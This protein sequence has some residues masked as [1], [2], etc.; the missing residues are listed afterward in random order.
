MTSFLDVIA[1]D[2]S[3]RRLASRKAIVAA[4]QRVDAQFGKF[5]A[6]YGERAVE[7][8]A[9]DIRAVVLAAADEYGAEDG[10]AIYE[11]LLTEY[12]DS[13][14]TTESKTASV[15]ESRRVKMCPFHKEVVDISLA[16]GEPKAGFEAMSQHWGGKSHCQGDDYAGD[17]CNFK[18][19]M[20]TQSFWDER[21]EKAEQR[22]REREEAAELEAQ[23]PVEEEVVEDAPVVE[24]V[25]EDA[26]ADNV[27]EVDFGGE[28]EA[29]APVADAPEVPMSM[30][31]S[32]KEA[33]C[34]KCGAD[35]DGELCEDCSKE[36][37]VATE[38]TGLGG[39]VP[40]IDKRKWTPKTVTEID[41][42]GDDSR[43]PT[44]RQDVVEAGKPENT[45]RLEQV[46]ENVTERVDVTRDADD[47][48]GE[49]GSWTDGPKSAISS[50][51]ESEFD[52]F[53]PQ[54]DV[55]RAVLA[56]RNR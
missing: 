5:I 8:A 47:I 17:K 29:E 16:Q 50:L 44:K 12:L 15:K 27:V 22:K 37:K 4:K 21:K 39:P 53:L 32:T 20:T 14:K 36:S 9:D 42:E 54:A 55:H 35:C 24:D 34:A 23:Q 6:T 18:P 46:G 13:F 48:V 41:T 49:G 7:H 38:T 43:N 30:A 3:G 2:D 31:A 26:P 19:A 33:N 11:S 28:Q 25:V 1:A 56:H 40:T 52:G 51:V 10:Q 45:T